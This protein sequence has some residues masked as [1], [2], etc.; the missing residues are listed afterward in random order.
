MNNSM[1]DRE[2]SNY[3][4]GY[5]DG[6]LDRLIGSYSLI[7][8]PSYPWADNYSQGYADGWAG[9]ENRADAEARA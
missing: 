5:R 6:H 8:R 4:E 2:T 9:R 3:R 1:T 7:D